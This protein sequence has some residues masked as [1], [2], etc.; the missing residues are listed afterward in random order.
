MTSPHRTIRLGQIDFTNVWPVSHYFPIASFGDTVEVISQI[1]TEL[2]Q[3]MRL[4]GIDIGPISSFAYGV[5]H[6]KYLLLPD[7]SVSAYGPVQ[8]ILLFYKGSL[9]RALN[10]KIALTTASATS[11]NLLKIILEKFHGGHPAYSFAAPSL[12]G[13][14]EEN[15]GALLIGDDAIRASWLNQ[16]Y[17][18]LDLGQEWTRLTG[19]WMSF[20]VWAIRRETALTYPQ[21]ITDIHSAFQES[22]RKALAEPNNMIAAAT[23]RIGGTPQFWTSYFAGLSHD[24]TAEQRAGVQLYFKY[25]VELG[26]LPDAVPLNIWTDS[27]K[28]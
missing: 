5:D 11:V 23:E 28:Q 21:L 16:D 14:M 27:R 10:G 25:A 7:L 18:V 2:N 17:K 8:S 20:A 19:H 15:D 4:G 9:D 6:D 24:F 26:V 12:H 13:M 1:P 22:K 3:S